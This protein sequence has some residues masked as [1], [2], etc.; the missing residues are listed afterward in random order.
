MQQNLPKLAIISDVHI[1]SPFLLRHKFL[2]FLNALPRN[3]TLIL[4]GDTIDNPYQDLSSED[5]AVL[6]RLAER[7]HEINII[8]IEGNHDQDY[9]PGHPGD[10]SFVKEYTVEDKRLL[11]SHGSYFDN[12]M[13]C[14]RWFIKLFKCLHR[15]RV[16]IGAPPVHVAEYAKKWRLLY[17]YLHN[18]VIRNAIEHAK[19][20][21]YRAVS[22]GHVHEAEHVIVDGIEYVNTG[23][24]T[25][26]PLCYATL[27]DGVIHLM[28]WQGAEKAPQ[29][30]KH[31]GTS[32]EPD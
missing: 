9:R 19:E 32:G 3:G 8:W 26:E 27:E 1:G 28:K 23:A 24:W 22:C 13:P 11:V 6:E 21:G 5:R 20:N 7:S 4:N 15:L 12:V 10:M 14:H 29:R 30:L 18:T 25:E 2:A 16:K 31:P 17:N